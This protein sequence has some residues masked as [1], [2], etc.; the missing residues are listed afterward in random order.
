M[1]PSFPNAFAEYADTRILVI[2]ASSGIGAA[3][4]LAFAECGARVCL[5]YH[6]GV[7]RAEA[8]V[9]DLAARG[10]AA[11]TVGG[12]LTEAGAGATIVTAAAESL[13]GLDRLINVAGAPLG[14]RPLDA[15]PAEV[16]A[17]VLQLNL[18]AVVDASRAALP[19]LREALAAGHHPAI[20]HTSSIAARSG[21]GRGIPIYA[22][23]KAGV[24]G[25]TRALARELGPE[26][27]RVNCVAPGY[28]DTPIHDG[29]ST[30][31][32]RA[33]YV[34]ATPMARAGRA[35]ECVGAY[36]YLASHRL[37]S[38]VTGQTLAVNGGLALL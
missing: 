33:G 31:E 2:G 13:G 19:Y 20:I 4:A 29:F 30:D 17:N 10:L 36:L 16:I 1:T 21:G 37:A 11:T 32:D 5:H 22:A 3:V 28:I 24:E 34:R 26:G 25:L 7:D 23:A 18:Q 8:L 14:R 12:D 15:T 35:D 38:F 6:R 9:A 27:I